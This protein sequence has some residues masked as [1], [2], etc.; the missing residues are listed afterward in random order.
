MRRYIDMEILASVWGLTC[1]KVIPLGGWRGERMIA[2]ESVAL[3]AKAVRACRT[4]I[5]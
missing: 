2:G 5:A 3:L 4:R 1:W